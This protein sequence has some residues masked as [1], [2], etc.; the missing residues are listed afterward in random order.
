MWMSLCNSSTTKFK[1]CRRVGFNLTENILEKNCC[2][3]QPRVILTGYFFKKNTQKKSKLK[4]HC[5]KCNTKVDAVICWSHS[6]DEEW[7]QYIS[8]LSWLAAKKIP[9]TPMRG[10]MTVFRLPSYPGYS[11]P[12][13]S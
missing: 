10:V 11:Q 3:F 1:D 6:V 12:G 9:T 7:I 13:Y 8:N 4:I 2:Q 5:C